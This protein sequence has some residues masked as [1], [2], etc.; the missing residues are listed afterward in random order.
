[1]V[2]QGGTAGRLTRVRIGDRLQT[3]RRSLKRIFLAPF[4]AAAKYHTF[5][6]RDLK[7]ESFDFCALRA[8]QEFCV[9]RSCEEMKKNTPRT[10]SSKIFSDER[11]DPLLSQVQSKDAESLLGETGL[12]GQLKKRLAERM[13]EAELNHP[14]AEQSAQGKTGNHRNGSSAKTVITPAGD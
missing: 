6:L 7:F 13:L 5:E 4:S 8:C 10:Q 14:L 11:I 3:G 1:M 12:A 9:L 2:G